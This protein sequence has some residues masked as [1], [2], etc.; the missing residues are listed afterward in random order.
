MLCTRKIVICCQ[1]DS[2]QFLFRY[3]TCMSPV[4]LT[5]MSNYRLFDYKTRLALIRCHCIPGICV[6]Y[7]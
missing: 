1:C 3:T 7:S 6:V 2:K 5:L 4:E